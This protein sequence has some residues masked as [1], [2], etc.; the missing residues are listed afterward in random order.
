MNLILELDPGFHAAVFSVR[1]ATSVLRKPRSPQSDRSLVT[2]NRDP[3][4]ILLFSSLELL[5][6]RLFNLHLPSAASCQFSALFAVSSRTRSRRLRTAVRDPLFLSFRR[7]RRV[8]NDHP[9][10]PVPYLSHS[11]SRRN[12]SRIFQDA[13]GDTKA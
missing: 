7:F 6:V 11:I 8:T 3:Y 1:S 10:L 2:A 9:R 13:L 12:R 4:A 5:N